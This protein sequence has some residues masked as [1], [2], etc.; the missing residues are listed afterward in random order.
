MAAGVTVAGTT[1]ATVAGV[2][3]GGVGAVVGARANPLGQAAWREGERVHN[4]QT[5]DPNRLLVD[6]IVNGMLDTSTWKMDAAAGMVS[7]G[8]GLG[9]MSYLANKGLIQ[10]IPGPHS[11]PSHNTI[12]L[13]PGQFSRMTVHSHP[14]Q[15]GLWEALS[16]GQHFSIVVTNFNLELGTTILAEY[17]GIM[18]PDLWNWLNENAFQN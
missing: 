5:F 8:V 4:G 12:Q 14:M 18:T 2:G 15:Q 7:A 10:A 16:P 11:V 9:G 1:T 13:L 3:A 17:S 6:A